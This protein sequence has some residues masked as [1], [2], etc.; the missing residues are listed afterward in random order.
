MF[1]QKK[2]YKYIITKERCNKRM[3]AL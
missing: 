3:F 1:L 2:I